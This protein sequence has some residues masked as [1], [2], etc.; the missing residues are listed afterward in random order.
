MQMSEAE[1]AVKQD[2]RSVASVVDNHVGRRIRERRS[3]L[4]L[5]QQRLAKEMGLSYQQIQKYES[6]SNRVSAGRLF[7]LARIL[8]IDV[9]WFYEGLDAVLG[10]QEQEAG[11]T[12][13]SEKLLLVDTRVRKAITELVDALSVTGR[14]H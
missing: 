9:G 11:L 14:M 6:G 2:E 5:T 4:R 7:L 1:V 8:N 13:T 12:G 10:E 3:E